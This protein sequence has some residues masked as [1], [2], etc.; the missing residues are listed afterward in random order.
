ISK[1]QPIVANNADAHAARGVLLFLFMTNLLWS[2]GKKSLFPSLCSG[3]PRVKTREVFFPFPLSSLHQAR[4]SSEAMADV[5]EGLVEAV[6]GVLRPLVKRLLA[7]G[8]PFGCVEARLRELFVQVAETELALPGRRQTDSR[9]ALV[10][11]INRKEVRRIRSAD[12]ST[13]A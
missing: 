5:R 9:V 1:A 12:K 3:D 2:K 6:A 4:Y 13:A 7:A 11:G 8:V 10:T